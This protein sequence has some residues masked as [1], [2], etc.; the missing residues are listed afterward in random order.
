MCQEKDQRE[1]HD[2]TKLKKY[3]VKLSFSRSK[4]DV[5]DK[6]SYTPHFQSC[7]L[8]VTFTSHI[9]PCELSMDKCIYTLCQCLLIFVCVCCLSFPWR[10]GLH[11]CRRKINKKIKQIELW[12]VV[13]KIKI[14]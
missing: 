4:Y 13:L 5:F 2:K 12:T 8:Y 10:T 11:P 7:F 9:I 3:L 14:K 1:I 6:Y